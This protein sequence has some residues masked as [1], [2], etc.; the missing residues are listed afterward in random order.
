ML[1]EAG[2]NP[3]PQEG[4]G[5][6]HYTPLQSWRVIMKFS[7]PRGWPPTLPLL[8]FFFP[9][10]VIFFFG[11]NCPSGKFNMYLN[12]CLISIGLT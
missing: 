4:E 5:R 12:T 10:L 3:A 6:D 1:V 7:S 2:S 9:V 11:Y 8:L